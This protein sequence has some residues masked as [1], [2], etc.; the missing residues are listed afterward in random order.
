MERAILLRDWDAYRR[1]YLGR[2][3]RYMRT[4]SSAL[5]AT[6]TALN[7]ASENS[8]ALE[9]RAA[10]LANIGAFDQ[11]EPL[12]DNDEHREQAPGPT[13]SKRIFSSTKGSMAALWN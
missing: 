9:E 11:A 3:H 7:Y 5:Y 2:Y 12:I 10:T 8:A 1:A 13:V 4:E 6:R